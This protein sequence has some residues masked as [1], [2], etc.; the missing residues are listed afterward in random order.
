V[1]RLRDRILPPLITALGP[2]LLA[3]MAL[4]WRPRWSGSDPL[5]LRQKR[6]TKERFIVALWHNTLLPLAWYFR[7][8]PGTV[9]VSRHGDGE[10]LVRVLK[11][12][13]YGVAR[14][15][16]TRGG[17]RALREM[18]R[19]ARQGAGDFAITPDG[20][21]GPANKAHPGI[22]YFAAA[23]GFPIV[24]VAMVP[25]RAWRLRSWDRF[26]IP[27]PG[28]RIAIVYGE[29]L[30]V[31]RDAIDG[32]LQAHLTRYED[33]MTRAEESAREYLRNGW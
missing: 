3:L 23:S 18:V 32:D 22:G 21:K 1:T 7:G 5:A 11:R 28:A 12:L 26:Q 19:I 16:S 30:L 14:G 6:G 8:R 20:P 2:P 4:T 10:F 13:G 27:K 24:P 31:P 17:A 9:L 15:S 29:P 25:D 33:A